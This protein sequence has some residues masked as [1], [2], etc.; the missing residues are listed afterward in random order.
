MHRDGVRTVLPRV[1][2]PGKDVDVALRI[3]TPARRGRYTLAVD[4]VRESIAW[5]SDTGKSLHAH[6]VPGKVIWSGAA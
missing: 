3:T 5:Y 1:V 6:P 2:R 4:M